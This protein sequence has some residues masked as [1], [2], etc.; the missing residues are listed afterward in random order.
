MQCWTC[1]FS[2]TSSTI[3]PSLDAKSLPH[4]PPQTDRSEKPLL[5]RLAAIAFLDVAGYSRLMGV[6]EET[7]LCEWLAL[8][9]MV[10]EP[11]V[12]SWRGRIVNR[13]GDGVLIEFRSALDAFHWAV[14]VQNAIVSRVHAGV[15]MQVRIAVHLGDVIVDAEGEVQG[16][17]VNTVVRLQAYAEPGGIVVSQA[18]ANEVLGKTAAAFLDL[19]ELRLRNILRPVHAFRLRTPGVSPYG[20]NTFDWAVRVK[21]AAMAA[22]CVHPARM[23]LGPGGL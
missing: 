22:N 17:R 14:D 19:G 6:D 1:A 23:V 13:A 7:T 3:C 20:I 18:I 5:R 4:H 12:R 2:P 15:P 16:D 8:R 21:P 9:C 11:R 10:I